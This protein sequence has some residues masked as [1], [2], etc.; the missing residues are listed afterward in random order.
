MEVDAPTCG[1][2]SRRWADAAAALDAQAD[3]SEA[4]KR[5]WPDRAGFEAS[6][7]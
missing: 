1:V 4:H 2:V 3:H 7:R 5:W 6:V